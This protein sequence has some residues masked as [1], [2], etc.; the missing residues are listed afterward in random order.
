M[1]RLNQSLNRLRTLDYNDILQGELGT[2]GSA[3][4]ETQT[5]L[6]TPVAGTIFTVT[7]SQ[8]DKANSFTYTLPSTSSLGTYREFALLDTVPQKV[9]RVVFTGVVHTANDDLIIKKGYYYKNV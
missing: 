1:V 9:D 5:D 3:I 7:K 6:V 4:A 8:A 2:D